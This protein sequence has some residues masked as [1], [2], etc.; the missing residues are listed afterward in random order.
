VL[1]T[2]F[3]GWVYGPVKPL[4]LLNNYFEPL[5]AENKEPYIMLAQDWD[6]R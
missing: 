2:P 3:V 6:G 1:K 5:Y 4:F